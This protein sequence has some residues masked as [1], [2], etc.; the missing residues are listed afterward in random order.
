MR[1]EALNAEFEKEEEL[2]TND[3]EISAGVAARPLFKKLHV[4]CDN[5]FKQLYPTGCFVTAEMSKT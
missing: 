3:I 4:S 1:I 2:E 5:Q